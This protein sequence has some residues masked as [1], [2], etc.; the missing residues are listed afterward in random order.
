MT[1]I[2]T[3]ENLTALFPQPKPL[4]L[5][6]VVQKL[7]P[8]TRHFLSLCSMAVYST[9]NPQGHVDT[10]PRGGKAGFIK[11]L[12]DSTLL[13]P[14]YAGNHR[15]DTLKNILL[16]SDQEMGIL[17]FAPGIEETLRL[18][19]TAKIFDKTD[20]EALFCH[21]DTQPKIVIQF[22]LHT[23]Y[24]QC[25]SALKLAQLWRKSPYIKAKEWPSIYKIIN[26][27]IIYNLQNKD[28]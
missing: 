19:G 9:I 17:C 26:D 20:N 13:L 8:H 10:S 12:N 18:K 6:K 22:Q 24:F 14:E 2:T 5:D 7:D 16:S 28:K 11:V 15:L 1:E 27:Q 23:L 21:F 3:L 4:V 25:S